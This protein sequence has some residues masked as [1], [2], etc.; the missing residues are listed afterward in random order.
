MR[1]AESEEQAAVVSRLHR[2]PRFNRIPW[3]GSPSAARRTP[4][5]V[6]VAKMLGMRPG[7]PDLL[8]L[9]PSKLGSFIGLALEFKNP[10]GK[11]KVS[12]D[13]AEWHEW[14]RAAGWRVEVPINRHEAWAGICDHLGIEP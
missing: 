13:Q 7:V 11:G 5:E 9:C 1:Y 3:F 4:Q 6:A 14:L 10:N 8:I 2:D 12:K